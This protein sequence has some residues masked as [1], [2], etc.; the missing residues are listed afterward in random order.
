MIDLAIESLDKAG[1]EVAPPGSPQ[2][3]CELGETRYT[4]PDSDAAY[5]ELAWTDPAAQGGTPVRSDA[6][7]SAKRNAMHGIATG[8][9]EGKD[10]R[11]HI[12]REMPVA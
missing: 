7:F 2:A 10:S 9:T 3:T 5:V 11:E 6:E 8:I 12:P 4:D 1:I